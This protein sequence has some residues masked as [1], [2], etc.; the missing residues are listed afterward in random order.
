MERAVTVVT[1]TDIRIITQVNTEK[2]GIYHYFDN[3]LIMVGSYFKVSRSISAYLPRKVWAKVCCHDNRD[4]M[5]MLSY[6]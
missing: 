6:S 1:S 5:Y 3:T 4:V 2:K